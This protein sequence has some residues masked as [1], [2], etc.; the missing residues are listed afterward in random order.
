MTTNTNN[1]VTMPTSPSFTDS[2]WSLIRTI[3][4][5]VSP[6]TGQQKTQEFANTYWSASL[7]L[8]PMKRA[9]AVLWQS[10]LANCRGSVNS[11]QLADP[12]AK[13]NQGT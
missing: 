11:F 2:E 6:F 7:T 13:T 4:T 9:Q 3:G 12:D 10:F 1:I 8:P 5:T